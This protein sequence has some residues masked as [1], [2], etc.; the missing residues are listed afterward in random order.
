MSEAEVLI[1]KGM[2][3]ICSPLIT[4]LKKDEKPPEKWGVLIRLE[5][6]AFFICLN[7]LQTLINKAHDLKAK[8][9]KDKTAY[10]G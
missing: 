8:Y 10:V 4:I 7:C 2:C 6:K 3:G 5:G 1:A 9:E